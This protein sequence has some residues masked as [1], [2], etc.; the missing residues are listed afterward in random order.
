MPSG[1]GWPSRCKR[2]SRVNFPGFAATMRADFIDHIIADR[3][4]LSFDQQPF[5]AE[6]IVRD[7]W[8]QGGG[9]PHGFRV[10]AEDAPDT[11][12]L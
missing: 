9:A 6:R 4:V 5:Y 1:N 2:I 7:I 8:Q 12:R 3:A 11:H 10:D